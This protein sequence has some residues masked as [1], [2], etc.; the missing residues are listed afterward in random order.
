V[1]RAEQSS[2]PLRQYIADH[3]ASYDA[4]LHNGPSLFE[5][6]G[7]LSVEQLTALAP[8][9]PRTSPVPLY[10]GCLRAVYRPFLAE[11][12][13]KSKLWAVYSRRALVFERKKI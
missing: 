1:L 10:K 12:L 6:G 9:A 5:W 3:F 11:R 13:L 8:L 4:S 7:F 2:A